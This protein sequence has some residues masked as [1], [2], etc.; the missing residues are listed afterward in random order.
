[1]T[2]VLPIKGTF[3]K[4][5]PDNFGDETFEAFKLAC[6]RFFRKLRKYLPELSA[7]LTENFHIQAA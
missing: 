5:I 1:M 2:T 3:D 7:L 6:Q 4:V